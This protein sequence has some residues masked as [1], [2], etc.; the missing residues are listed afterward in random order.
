VVHHDAGALVWQLQEQQAHGGRAVRLQR[1]VCTVDGRRC[2]CCHTPPSTLLHALLRL[3]ARRP[4][5]RAHARSAP[6]R[7]CRPRRW[8]FC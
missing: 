1:R 2:P 6:W 5:A 3:P 7:P 8:P 4:P